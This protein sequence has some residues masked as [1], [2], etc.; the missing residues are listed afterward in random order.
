MSLSLCIPINSLSFSFR[1]RIFFQMK[2]F[3]ARHVYFLRYASP[4]KFKLVFILLIRPSMQLYESSSSPLSNLSAFS[5]ICHDFIFLPVILN[6]LYLLYQAFFF[7][8]LIITL[9]V[10]LSNIRFSSF[11]VS[12]LYLICSFSSF[13]FPPLSLAL[14]LSRF[15]RTHAEP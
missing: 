15:L 6:L 3:I 14:N 9:R 1:L 10:P 11:L 8:I 4:W 13:P 2:F 7:L 5:L 12:F